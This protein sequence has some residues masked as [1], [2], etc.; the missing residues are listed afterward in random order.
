MPQM[1]G[2]M[3]FPKTEAYKSQMNSQ[4]EVYDYVVPADSSMSR[5]EEADGN[6]A[7]T[8]VDSD[9]SLNPSS[10]KDSFMAGE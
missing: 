9:L 8:H 7:Q 6:V 1:E 5:V 10:R 3:M 2:S 4:V